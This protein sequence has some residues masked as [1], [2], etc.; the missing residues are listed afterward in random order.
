MNNANVELSSVEFSQFAKKLSNHLKGFEQGDFSVKLLE[1]VSP[2]QKEPVLVLKKVIFSFEQKSSTQTEDDSYVL[3]STK[4]HESETSNSDSIEL[5]CIE[6]EELNDLSL[7]ESIMEITGEY[8]ITYSSS[9]RCPVLYFIFYN[10]G[11]VVLQIEEI[12]EMLTQPK[13]FKGR[14]LFFYNR[15]AV[16]PRGEFYSA[17]G[18]QDHPYLQKPFYFLHPC[19]T[20]QLMGLVT[21]NFQDFDENKKEINQRDTKKFENY[22]SIWLGLVGPIVL[23]YLPQN[24]IWPQEPEK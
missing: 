14:D 7:E 1:S 6:D 17:I 8:H 13:Q 16:L 9:Y 2:F 22:I 19:E 12:E 21:N 15:N 24:A 20:H 18:I 5:L 10:Q 23:L 11:G 4:D 3:A